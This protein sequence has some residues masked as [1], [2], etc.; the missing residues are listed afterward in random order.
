MVEKFFKDV[1]EMPPVSESEMNAAMTDLS[2]VDTCSNIQV[3]KFRTAV[4]QMCMNLCW[5]ITSYLYNIIFI[6]S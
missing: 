3:V 1:Q 6:L 4:L 5:Y 2:M